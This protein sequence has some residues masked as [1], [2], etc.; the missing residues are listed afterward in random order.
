MKYYNKLVLRNYILFIAILLTS[1]KIKA[2]D[3]YNYASYGVGFAVSNARPFADLKKNYTDRVYAASLNYYY[4]P[5]LPI[6][7]EVQFGK[8]RG[9]GNTVAE[10]SGTRRF[11]NNFKAVM[12]HFDIQMGEMMDYE[13]NFV[14]NL[15][16]NFYLGTGFGFIIN[17]VDANRESIINPGYVFPGKNNSFNGLI[18][19]RFGYEVKIYNG[20]GEPNIRIDFGYQHNMTFGEGLDGYHDSGKNFKNNALDQYRQLSVGIKVNF[21]GE[22]SYDKS[23]SGF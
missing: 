4:T 2:Q 23:I 7:L 11:S 12:M 10:D 20:Y 17:N 5:Y 14:L 1:A 22:S 19:I 3:N 6:A 13:D 15:A 16:K 18:P 21:G 9:G 8:L